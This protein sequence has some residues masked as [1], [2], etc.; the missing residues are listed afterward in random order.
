MHSPVLWSK[1]DLRYP[2]PFDTIFFDVDGILIDTTASFHA[3]DIGVAEYIAGTML[4]LDWGQATEQQRLTIQDVDIFK[5]AGGY[6]NDWDMCYL[7][8]A[9]STARL[10]EWRGTALAERSTQ[11]WAT[12]SRAANLQGRGGLTWVREVIPASALPDYAVVGQVYR[13]YYWG[14]AELFKRY[15]IAARYLPDAQGL[16]QHEELLFPADLIRRLR[17]AGIAHFGIITGRVGPE[18]DSALE[19]IAAH[20]GEKWWEVVIPANVSA[21]PDP[22]A[23][24][25]AIEGT[26]ASGGLY[27]GDTADDFD[28]VRNYRQSQRAG[29]PEILM[30]M[31]VPN[32]DDAVTYKQRQPDFILRATADLLWCL[33]STGWRKASPHM[34]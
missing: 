26:E 18:V 16:I 10:R 21:K 22:K 7:L 14:A 8:A 5:Q 25:L 30:A 24:R 11:E 2:T 23:L 1:P 31:R 3:T 17:V 13:E 32:E 29:E 20:S 12:L 33:P 19:R 9:L 6:N 4:G 15:G 28:L 27:I 34:R